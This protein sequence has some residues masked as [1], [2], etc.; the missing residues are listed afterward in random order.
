M[1]GEYLIFEITVDFG[2]SKKKLKSKT[3][4]VW[5]FENLCWAGMSCGWGG[6]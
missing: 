4:Q 6:G 3:A 2:F 1:S 5:V